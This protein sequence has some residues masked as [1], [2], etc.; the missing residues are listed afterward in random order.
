MILRT[1][2]RRLSEAKYCESKARLRASNAASW[3]VLAA[4]SKKFLSSSQ[5]GS[6]KSAIAQHS[7]SLLSL[8]ICDTVIEPFSVNLLES[9]CV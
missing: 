3:E 8:R 7:R 5:S 2:K 1:E 6:V 4:A 9:I